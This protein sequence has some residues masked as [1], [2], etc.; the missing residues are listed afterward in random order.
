[1]RPQARQWCL[2]LRNV[3]LVWHRMQE[4]VCESG[5]HAGAI[6]PSVR[7]AS[8]NSDHSVWKSMTCIAGLLLLRDDLSCCS[9]L[10]ADSSFRDRFDVVS[11][12]LVVVVGGVGV[13]SI[14]MSVSVVG[15]DLVVVVSETVLFSAASWASNSSSSANSA[16]SLRFSSSLSS[17]GFWFSF[18]GLLS[19]Y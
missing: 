2:R 19:I 8:L 17:F 7:S 15:S 18:N 4:S 1:M 11:S 5:S 13:G 10:D 12:S 16:N 6:M 9:N 3:N 14:S